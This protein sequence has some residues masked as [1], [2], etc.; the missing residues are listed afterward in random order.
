MNNLELLKKMIFSDKVRMF[1]NIIFYDC[2]SIGR[3]K[4]DDNMIS[5]VIN[6]NIY[7]GDLLLIYAG[8]GQKI[9]EMIVF[10]EYV[11]KQNNKLCYSLNAKK[12]KIG[13][14]N[15]EE[16]IV[17]VSRQ[18]L[19]CFEAIESIKTNV[20]SKRTKTVT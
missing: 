1:D 12:I 8:L 13:Y 5:V 7:I 4:I 18:F 2:N 20:I 11:F 17:K 15:D 10:N 16:M 19:E 6:R 14:I 3:Y 9:D